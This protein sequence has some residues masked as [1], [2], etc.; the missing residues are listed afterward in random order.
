MDTKTQNE[1][2]DVIQEYNRLL[3]KA[4]SE[5][6]INSLYLVKEALG[7]ARDLREVFGYIVDGDEN[8]A[9]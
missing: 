1:I 9:A 3:I 2:L 8:N 4:D 7:L 5:L 6:T